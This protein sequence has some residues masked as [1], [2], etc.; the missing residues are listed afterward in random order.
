MK[1]FLCHFCVDLIFELCFLVK[2][3]GVWREAVSWHVNMFVICIMKS[4][5]AHNSDKII[6]YQS[7][8]WHLFLS[9]HL[10]DISLWY[11]TDDLNQWAQRTMAWCPQKSFIGRKDLH[12]YMMMVFAPLIT[13]QWNNLVFECLDFINIHIQVWR[14][15]EGIDRKSE[16]HN[17]EL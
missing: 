6:S 9:N 2:A 17:S 12:L 8:F 4:G 14:N 13:T 1:P 15:L 3:W 7:T 5:R 10:V 11:R 16:N